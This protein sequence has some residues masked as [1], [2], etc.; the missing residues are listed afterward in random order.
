MD[1]TGVY[2][3]CYMGVTVVSQGCFSYVTGGVSR[4][5]SVFKRICV[6]QRSFKVVV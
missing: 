1:V 3:G 4:G 5:V 2:N 6:Y